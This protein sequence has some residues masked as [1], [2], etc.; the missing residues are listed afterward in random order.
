[1]ITLNF[2]WNDPKRY[3]DSEKFC[4]WIS[5][6]FES[7]QLHM[8]LITWLFH[9]WSSPAEVSYQHSWWTWLVFVRSCQKMRSGGRDSCLKSCS[10][11]TASP[12]HISA[13]LLT[14]FTVWIFAWDILWWY[15]RQSSSKRRCSRRSHSLSDMDQEAS[16]Q[17]ECDLLAFENRYKE[18][19]ADR[20]ASFSNTSPQEV[21]ASTVHQQNGKWKPNTKKTF[22]FFGKSW[23]DFCESDKYDRKETTVESGAQFLQAERARHVKNG[24]KTPEKKVGIAFAQFKSIAACRDIPSQPG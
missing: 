10:F 9:P 18:A 16:Q 3:D 6:L 1:M 15:H 2:R 12:R 13:W 11:P 20:F 24:Q 8:Q 23:A 4:R 17:H 14:I 22:D 21:H 5:Q 7:Y 19:D